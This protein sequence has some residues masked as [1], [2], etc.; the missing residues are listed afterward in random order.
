MERCIS[1]IRM[2][3]LTDKLKLNGD[4]TEFML[5]G[6]KQQLSKVNIDS[7]SVGSIKF[8]PVTVV[9]NLGTWFHSDLNL[10]EQILKTCK[11]GFSHLYN[12]RRIRKYLFLESA[13]TLVHA[14]IISRIDYCYS[15]LFGL[16]SV[17]LLKLQRLQNVAARLILKHPSL[18]LK[19]TLGDRTFSSLPLTHGT[20]CAALSHPSWGQF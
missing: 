16:P 15:L 7:L 1:D 14:F 6:A 8:A 2:W 9:R 13:S 17:H 3:M 20:T 5:I 11:S 4:K 19:K 12:I 10:Q 18:K